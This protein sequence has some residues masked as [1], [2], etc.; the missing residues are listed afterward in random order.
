MRTK[1][2][3]NAGDPTSERRST[4]RTK[5]PSIVVRCDGQDYAAVDL[6]LGGCRFFDYE[7]DLRPGES[8]LIELFLPIGNQQKGLPVRAEVVR[9][10]PDQNNA[11]ALCFVNL[12]PE[13]F[14]NFC[15]AVNIDLDS[16]GKA[17]M[18]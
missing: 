1:F 15:D 12:S 2:T 17:A 6:G 18:A 14:M 5:E 4:P 13:R 9:F 11:L 10:D 3:Q 7:G 8:T 16:H